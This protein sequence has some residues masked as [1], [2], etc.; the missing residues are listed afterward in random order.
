MI[1]K[2]VTEQQVID[3]VRDAFL[4]AGRVL[5]C[6]VMQAFEHGREREESPLGR[7]VF[8]Q[9]IEN[10][11][12]AVR[13]GM[14]LCQDT[15]FAVV[16]VEWGVQVGYDGDDLKAAIDEGVRQAYGTGYF[17]KSIVDDPVFDRRN[18]GDNTP[19][20]VT[21]EIVPGDA[22]R[23][24]AAPKGGGSE[25][26]SALRMF[27][28]AEGVEAIR[29][30][31]IDTVDKAGSNPCPPVIVGVG[32]GG[33]MDKCALLAKKALLREIGSSHRDPRY[34]KLE[35]ELLDGVNGLGIGPGGFGG[36]VTALA[37]H[38]ET[39]PCHIASMPCAVNMQCHSA[40]HC[41]IVL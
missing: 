41:E 1:V 19:A 36:R 16:F 9:L 38:V 12:I 3:A 37:V 15:G 24:T 40:R 20:A 4:T 21:V 22:V 6:D 34:A 14:A 31:V 17:R 27:K 39:H 35:R 18:T 7:S 26:M 8:D 33:T 30:F 5:P 10:A 29:Q 25:N 28:P 32:I 13:D 11:R 23:I 2:T